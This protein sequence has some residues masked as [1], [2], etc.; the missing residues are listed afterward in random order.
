MQFGPRPEARTLNLV[1]G[2]EPVARSQSVEEEM[3]VEVPE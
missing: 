1:E 2:W 3:E